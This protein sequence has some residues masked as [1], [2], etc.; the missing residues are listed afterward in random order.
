MAK[1]LLENV[2]LDYPIYKTGALSLRHKILGAATGGLISSNKNKTTI[3]RALSNINLEIKEGDRL[4]VIGHNGAGKST[5]LRC[6]SG[7]YKPTRGKIV[8]EGS[9]GSFLEIGAGLEPELSGYDNIRRLLMLR[10]V[11]RKNELEN[12]VDSIK[13][14]SEL[15][16]FLD[17]PVRTYSSGMLTRLIFSTITAKIPEIM[18][19]DEFFGVGDAPFQEKANKRLKNGIDQASILVFASHSVEL[20]KSMCNQFV[21]LTNG[22]LEETDL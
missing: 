12:L 18:I 16:D 5:L 14:F 13:C 15:D 6:L 9:L 11:F 10:G 2:F 3:V 19:M 20:M 22:Y 21:R 1:I 4:G 7:I 8:C 17:L